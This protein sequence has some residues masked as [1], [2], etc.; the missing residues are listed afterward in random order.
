MAQTKTN[1]NGKAN[2]NGSQTDE[3]VGVDA[4][5]EHTEALKVSLRDSLAKTTDLIASLKRHKRANKSVQSALAWLRQ[6]SY[7]CLSS[8]SI[9]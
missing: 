2:S 4:I 5:I 9:R 8:C 3:I 6:L 1:E 7:Q